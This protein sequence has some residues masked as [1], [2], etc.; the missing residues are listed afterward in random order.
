[1]YLLG[2]EEPGLVDVRFH[3][4]SHPTKK[5]IKVKLS[6]GQLD[7][8]LLPIA[9]ASVCIER[10][11]CILYWSTSCIVVLS[12]FYASDIQVSRLGLRALETQGSHQRAS[13]S[14]WAAR[15]RRKGGGGVTKCGIPCILRFPLSGYESYSECVVHMEST[16]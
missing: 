2:N 6:S 10:S 11:Y 7:R 8:H 1:M 3:S 4:S 16:L 12:V 9:G 15:Q 14:Y 13:C 5:F